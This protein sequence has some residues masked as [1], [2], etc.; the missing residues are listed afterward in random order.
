MN[1]LVRVMWRSL[2]LP[3]VCVHPFMFEDVNGGQLHCLATV[4]A[5]VV[6]QV[7][8]TP[9]T[10]PTHRFLLPRQLCTGESHSQ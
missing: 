1:A 4:G 2:D 7:G 8:H 10:T 5:V 9:S 3:H 6:F